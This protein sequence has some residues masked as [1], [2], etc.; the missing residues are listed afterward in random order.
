MATK[1]KHGNYVATIDYD[2]DLGKFFG[3]VI[4]ISDVVTFYGSSV[5]ELRREFA[6]SIN[7]HLAYCKKKGIQPSRPF[8]GRFN[9]RLP[10]ESHAVVSAAAAVSGKT[11]NV[12]V[13]ET[14]EREAKRALGTRD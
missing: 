14:L 4:N 9:V 12:W 13:S 3:E 2:A 7:A 6:R 5:A 1:M 11:M 8:S 10:P